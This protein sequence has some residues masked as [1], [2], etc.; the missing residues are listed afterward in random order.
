M[1][2]I[3]RPTC[4]ADGRGVTPPV[5]PETRAV[6]C[7]SPLQHPARMHMRARVHVPVRP[8]VTA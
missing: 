7:V 1:R 6:T 3:L 2:A 4:Y 8:T 5:A